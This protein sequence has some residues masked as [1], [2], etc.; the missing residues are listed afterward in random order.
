MITTNGQEGFLINNFA[1]VNSGFSKEGKFFKGRLY[2]VLMASNMGS[3]FD[4]DRRIQIQLNKIQ[5]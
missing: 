5:E 3:L 2:G 4:L 1:T